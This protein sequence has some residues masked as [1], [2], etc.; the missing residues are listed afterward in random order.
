MRSFASRTRPAFC[1]SQQGVKRGTALAPVTT[2]PFRKT[3][4]RYLRYRVAG[5]TGL[6]PA[7]SCVTET[8]SDLILVVLPLSMVSHPA[9]VLFCRP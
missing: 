2:Q 9:Q 6:E 8:R 5:A 4:Q 7:A 1:K 3:L